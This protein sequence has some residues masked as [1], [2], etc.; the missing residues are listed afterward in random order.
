MTG[1]QK[2]IYRLK[3]TL[4]RKRASEKH[5][6]RRKVLHTD[7]EEGQLKKVKQSF[8]HTSFVCCIECCSCQYF[9]HP[10][11]GNHFERKRVKLS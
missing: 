2:K 9:E 10:V 5:G 6:C 3:K 1:N 8:Q 11:A 4:Q 7:V